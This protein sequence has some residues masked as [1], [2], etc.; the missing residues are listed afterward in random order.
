MSSFIPVIYP[1]W[2]GRHLVIPIVGLASPI[3]PPLQH[4]LAQ[5]RAAPVEQY[6]RTIAGWSGQAGHRDL[7]QGSSSFDDPYAFISHCPCKLLPQS[8]PMIP[9]VSVRCPHLLDHLTVPPS[10][11][12]PHV[13]GIPTKAV[14]L[15]HVFLCGST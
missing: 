8:L 9:P 1:L 10:V 6:R 13:H 5:P 7:C 14:S 4:P 11:Q 3:F 15:L 2:P 12:V